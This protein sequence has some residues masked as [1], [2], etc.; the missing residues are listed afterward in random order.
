MLENDERGSNALSR[1]DCRRMKSVMIH[2][3]S[4]GTFLLET[5]RPNRRKT[6]VVEFAH[7]PCIAA[8]SLTHYFQE[9]ARASVSPLQFI[10]APIKLSIRC[11]FQEGEQQVR[12]GVVFGGGRRERDPA[13]I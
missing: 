2:F 13:Q 7:F 1:I 10:D 6:I 3:Q 9:A 12:V 8:H 4:F 5:G 11:C